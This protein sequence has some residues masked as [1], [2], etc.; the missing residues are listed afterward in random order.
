MFAN[1]VRE[2]ASAAGDIAVL[3]GVLVAVVVLWQKVSTEYQ[4][5]LSWAKARRKSSL[6][7]PDQDEINTYAKKSRWSYDTLQQD[8]KFQA[9]PRASN[10]NFRAKDHTVATSSTEQTQT[11]LRNTYDT[12]QASA[13][14][15]PVKKGWIVWRILRALFKG[16]IYLLK[17][18]ILLLLEAFGEAVEK[19]PLG[20]LVAMYVTLFLAAPHSESAAALLNTVNSWL[21]LMLFF[22]RDYVDV[23]FSSES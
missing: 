15:Q 2:L 1:S 11:R 6:I 18:A 12:A 14:E 3:V 20:L 22:L 23:L 4:R 10:K 8:E 17:E 9:D 19:N 13:I 5:I 16:T 21:R 7:I